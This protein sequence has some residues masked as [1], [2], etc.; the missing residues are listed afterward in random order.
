MF[1]FHRLKILPEVGVDLCDI[2]FYCSTFFH[3]C[4][5]HVDMNVFFGQTFNSVFFIR[6]EIDTKVV[7]SNSPILHFRLYILGS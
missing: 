1:I 6:I 3:F 2:K 7:G 5:I 4:R